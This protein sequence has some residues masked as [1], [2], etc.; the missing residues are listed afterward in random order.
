MQ[1]SEGGEK[2]QQLTEKYSLKQYNNM[3]KEMGTWIW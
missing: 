1:E 3:M 2:I